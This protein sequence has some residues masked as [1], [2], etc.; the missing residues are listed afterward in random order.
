MRFFIRVTY[1][2]S[3]SLGTGIG[4]NPCYGGGGG[5]GGGGRRPAKQSCLSAVSKIRIKPVSIEF[6]T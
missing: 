6:N 1:R 5:R 2:V 3:I 4:S